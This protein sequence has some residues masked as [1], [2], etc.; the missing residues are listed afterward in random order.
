MPRRKGPR[1]PQHHPDADVLDSP[2]R[3]AGVAAIAAFVLVVPLVFDAASDWPFVVPKALLTHA[4]AYGLAALLVAHAIRVRRKAVPWSWLHVPVLAYL[5]VTTLAAIFAEDRYM[6]IFGS[7]SRMLGLATTASW[8]VLYLGVCAFVRTRSD[9]VTVVRA[10]LT[11]AVIML[12]YEAMQVAKVDPLRWSVDTAT[13]PISTTGQATTLGAYLSVVAIGVVAI[14][15]FS[16]ANDRRRMLALGGL[17]AILL[18]GSAFTGTRSSLVGLAAGA[19]ILIALL[20]LRGASRTRLRLVSAAAALSV[21]A[22]VGLVA[23]TPLGGRLFQSSSS[24]GSS[25]RQL[26]VA[27]LDVRAVL[28]SVALDAVRER[29]LLGYGP[30]NFTIAMEHHRPETGNVEARLSYATSAHGWVSQTAVDSGVLGV[31]A[32]LAI[33]VTTVVL[34][35]RSR[36]IAAA[37]VAG[38]MLTAY[39]GTGLTTISDVGTDWLFW[40]AVGFV[41]VAAQPTVESEPGNQSRDART[42]VRRSASWSAADLVCVAAALV[43]ALTA[44]GAWSA[45]RSAVSS[46][47][48]RLV[49]RSTDAI[50]SAS[51]ATSADPGRAD[52]LHDLGLAYIGAQRWRDASTAFERALAAA[53]WDVRVMGDLMK[54][55]LVLAQGGDQNARARALEL[56]DEV[57]RIDPNHADVQIGR[58]TVLQG[59][60]NNEGALQSVERAFALYPQSLIESWYVMATQLYV[61]VGRPGDGVAIAERGIRVLGQTVSL[62]L[63]LARALLA[64]GRPQDAL[65]Q[66]DA[67]LAADPNNGNA[68]QLRT[69]IQSALTR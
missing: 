37:A 33:I 20:A 46:T 31:A 55:E 62:R 32:F 53:P 15:F 66:V 5:L 1:A 12:G 27:S 54:V 59:L 30:D 65:A 43:L 50:R 9:I 21:L 63:E 11:G 14:A 60:G 22:L 61:S 69:Q 64:S 7:H 2:V 67:I 44:I 56:A 42:R 45:S 51:D 41:A 49:G 47:N 25:G 38:V 29:P 19:V 57:V 3:R 16:Y 52:Y 13:R 6:A 23:F 26:D 40:A 58:A 39:L 4:F 35:L 28:Y 36:A 18:V 48:A 34:V 24:G 10:G 17:A 68:K 8:T